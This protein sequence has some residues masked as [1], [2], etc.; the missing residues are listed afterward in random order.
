MTA[1]SQLVFSACPHDVVADPEKWTEFAH[2]LCERTPLKSEFRRHVSFEDFARHFNSFSLTYA[3][4]LHAIQLWSQ[5][6][7]IPLAKYE[8][9]YDEAVLITS[10]SS[11]RR[12]SFNRIAAAERGVRSIEGANVACVY[13]S[14]SHA[15][16]LIEIARKSPGLT[17]ESVFKDSYPNVLMSV[18]TGEAEC[19]IILKSVW[20]Q[21]ISMRDRVRSIYE[22]DAR[23][24]VHAFMLAP[25]LSKLTGVVR[26][27]LLQM[28][29]DPEGQNILDRLGC[30]RL[31]EFNEAGLSQLQASLEVCRFE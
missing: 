29:K 24:L 15:A 20:T 17:F 18:S 23:K 26:T 4:P 7:Y 30:E 11:G 6:G 16:A 10:N 31:V 2:Y 13:G 28:E 19:G 1:D 27:T 3:H 12:G 5:H 22:T 14:P 21:M 25:Q 8:G 9:T